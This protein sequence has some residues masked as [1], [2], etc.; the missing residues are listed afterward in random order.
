VKNLT[1]VGDGAETSS[2]EHMHDTLV[3][4]TLNSG[5]Q[6]STSMISNIAKVMDLKT[7]FVGNS[8]VEF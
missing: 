1:H 3:N 5:D 6:T 4:G 2:V 7:T 8:L